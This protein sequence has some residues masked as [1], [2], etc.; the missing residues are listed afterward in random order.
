MDALSDNKRLAK[1]TAFLYLRMLLLMFVSFYTS[2]IVLDQ[3]GSV[4]YGIYNVV[5][6]LILLFTFIQGSLSSSASRYL[7]YE[8]GAGTEQS[9]R[10]VFCM[11][12]NI[13]L[14]FVI[15]IVFFAE[16]I[17]LWYFYNKMVIPDERRIAG[18]VVY[19]LSNLSAIL[20]VISV[21]YTSM[22][23]AQEK[24]K[25]FAY[26]SI[27]EALAKL[28]IAF[29][30]YINGIDKLILY[31][32]L[33]LLTH[34]GVALLY[35]IYCK[36]KFNA[37][38][39]S[40]YWDKSMFKEMM[41]YNGWSISSQISANFVNQIMNLLL[42]MFFGPV[43]NAARAVSY[44][45]QTNISKFVV[46]FQIALN[47]QVIKQYAS[48]NL[49]RVLEL[50]TISIK[51]SFSLLFIIMFPLLVNA[52]FILSIWLKDVPQYTNI[53]IVIV[54]SGAIFGS[55]SNVFS[56]IAQ[57][58]NRLKIFSLLTIPLYLLSIPI[59]YILLNNG[60]KA[61]WALLVAS[62]VQF[63][64]LFIKFFIIRYIIKM[65]MHEELFVIGKCIGT[66][67]LFFII[68]CFMRFFGGDNFVM[69]LISLSCCFILAVVWS[70][71]CIFNN[72]ERSL[73]VISIKNKF[74]R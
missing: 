66:T 35:Y 33:L 10:R 14:L 62:L 37:S 60:A 44:Q 3:L 31:A 50:T 36:K 74:K 67:F 55:M 22:L 70:Y 9:L 25:Q 68:G 28:G 19:Q 51:V 53:F 26:L 15:L 24:M 27:I 4:D 38:K 5:G 23:I 52:D 64:E 58:A 57:A 73:L 32:S 16:T 29:C 43:V 45:V 48:Q 6:S 1:N 47:P 11:T 39:Y 69:N 34:L 20:T 59:V 13:H 2:R 30:L 65:P 46:N 21:P 49:K 72:Q 42:N 8:I 56:V 17:G 41:A 61:Y 54:C 40:L 7:S 18:L 12:M 63:L 71:F